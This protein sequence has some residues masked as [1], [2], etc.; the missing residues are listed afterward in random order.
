MKAPEIAGQA[1][2]VNVQTR[3]EQNHGAD[4]SFRPREPTILR[5]YG[6][7]FSLRPGS[8]LQ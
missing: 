5:K 7:Y 2:Q 4:Q 8:L 6:T 1:Q 3:A